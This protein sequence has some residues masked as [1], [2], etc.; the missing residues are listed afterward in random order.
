MRGSSIVLRF[1]KT[2]LLIASTLA[3][4]HIVGCPDPDT[5][6]TK[7]GGPRSDKATQWMKRASDELS[8]LDL[9]EAK[10]SVDKALNGA[11]GDPDVSMLAARIHL[12]R[13]DF[14]AAAKVLEGLE[15]S[16]AASLRARAYWYSDDLPKAS[17]NIVHA[18][19]DPAFK[20]PWA[21]PIR[22]LAGTQGTGRKPF[23]LKDSS[24][25]LVE[26]RMPRDL[27]SIMMVP[28]EI[29]GQASVAILDTGVPE[30]ILDQK[31][32]SSP[33]WVS[34]KFTSFDGS[35]SMEF[36]D[37]PAFVNDLSPF[38]KSQQIPIGAV[39]GMNFLRRMHITFDRLADQLVLRREDPALPPIFTRV[40]T[41]YHKGG[42]MLVRA[43]IS[44]AFDISGAL[45][46]DT[47]TEY[48]LAFPDPIWKKIGVN[49]AALQPNNGKTMSRLKK[50][51]IG[52]LDLGP[53]DAM[54][55]GVTGLDESLGKFEGIEVLGKVGMGF[56]AGM[57][58]TIGDNGRALW[59]ETDQ[60][61]PLVLA[62]PTAGS[63]WTP[64][65]PPPPPK[66]VTSA[67]A[68]ASGAPSSKPPAPSASPA[69]K[70]AASPA[71]KPAPSAS[72]TPKPAPASSK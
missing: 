23:T 31:A 37:V 35:R 40:P 9:T 66:V 28:C 65:T 12:A 60:N 38:T 64:K 18:L 45:H 43:T 24:A 61:T 26:M 67:S 39:I 69:P 48:P 44:D 62:P 33:G 30:V 7:K 59:L 58:V 56:L 19:E 4:P 54:A 51:T 13:L 20:D 27:G 10:D 68:K 36:R 2:V 16:E 17:E 71:P 34:F 14:K 41:A 55:S 52:G 21:K 11:P 63:G 32:R 42:G 15:G 8:A 49:T 25:R 29:D 72:P 22:E 1:A 50:I 6:A 3:V 57:R 46:V 53:A 47:G 5:G 70:P